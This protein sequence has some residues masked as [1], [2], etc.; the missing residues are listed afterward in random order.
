QNVTNFDK[1][2]YVL[3]EINKG[4]FVYK[5]NVDVIINALENPENLI[6]EPTGVYDGP[7]CF[8]YGKKSPFKVGSREDDIKQFFTQA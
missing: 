6:V 4:R 8:A 7:A 3:K 5:T 2:T 1:N